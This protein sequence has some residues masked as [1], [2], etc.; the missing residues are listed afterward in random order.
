[1]EEMFSGTKP[2]TVLL[3]T[4][5]FKRRVDTKMFNIGDLVTV[6]RF[7]N[8]EGEWEMPRSLSGEYTKEQLKKTEYLFYISRIAPYPSSGQIIDKLKTKHGYELYKV[9]LS[10]RERVGVYW[11]WGSFLETLQ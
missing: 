9:L 4:L 1:M 10:K 5:R 8:K 11:I 7:L 2:M 3:F 6:V